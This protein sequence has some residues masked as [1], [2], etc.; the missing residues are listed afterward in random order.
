[1][2]RNALVPWYAA[3]CCIAL[4]VAGSVRPAIAETPLVLSHAASI[5]KADFDVY[6]P[7]RNKAELDK[8]VEAQV[9]RQSPLYH[10]WLKPEEFASRFGPTAET[11]ASVTSELNSLGFQ[12]TEH[13]GQMLH[14]AASVA[15]VESV[16][17]V[18][19]NHARF[20]E[21]TEALVA[22]GALHLT[23][24]LAA[25]G[26]HIPQFTTVGPYRKHSQAAKI[27]SGARPD[28]ESSVYGPYL[29]ADL[30]QAYAYPSY[31]SVNASGITIGILMSNAYNLTD[32]DTYL[33]D[34]GIAVADRGKL[35]TVLIDGG[36][37]YSSSN[38][39]E[40]H[41]DIEQSMGMAIGASEILYNL[42]NLSNPVV[43]FGLN[44]IVSDNAVYVV[45]MSFGE[46]EVDYLASN[47]GGISQEY[48][49]QIEDML[50]E[51]GSSQGITF[52]AASGDHGSDP[53]S[54]PSGDPVLGVEE[55]ASD[56]YVTGVGGTNLETT[57][58]SGS[59]NSAY[60]KEFELPDTEAVG[61]WASGGGKSIFW[62]KPS[63]QSLVATGQTVRTVP[64]IAL[65]MG[66]CPSDATD[67]CEGIRS[68]DWLILGGEALGEIGTSASSPDIVGM[69]ALTAKLAKSRLGPM[70]K[71]LYTAGA[72]QVAH[73]TDII[74]RHS[75]ITGNNH[76]YTI[77]AP[78]DM[79]IG[80]GTPVA[81]KFIE[82]LLDIT[83]SVAGIPGSS[84]NP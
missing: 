56:P 27:P 40:T 5:E 65:H 52:V 39:A 23:P 73:P 25:S 4:V 2:S 61:V 70:N 76:N 6:F 32:I 31:T 11:I 7:L 28:N 58:T 24:A 69:F 17:G 74:F 63:Y 53:R 1:M 62:A 66:G 68:A 30:R 41:L 35:S 78:Y 15:S 10:Q 79:V 18:R 49:V 60:V 13:R 57:Y 80:L 46:P 82:G 72:Y 38:S 54:A 50:F 64:D 84:T 16:F 21:G 42:S 29:A 14:V 77:K 12:V 71:A 75:A 51:Q 20:A 45:N 19:I 43:L 47:N 83:L 8:L 48:L 59:Y 3:V 9:D 33:S 22:D 37:A 44:T 26:A 36:A 67:T 34:D 55:P 81:T